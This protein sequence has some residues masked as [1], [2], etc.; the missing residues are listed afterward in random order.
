MEG[1]Y[2]LKWKTWKNIFLEHEMLYLL[3][4]MGGPFT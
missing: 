1:K 2:F 4:L 3:F